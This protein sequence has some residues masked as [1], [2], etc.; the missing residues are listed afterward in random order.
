MLSRIIKFQEKSD[1]ELVFEIG[2]NSDLVLEN[3][4]TNNLIWTIEEFSKTKKGFLT[5]PTKFHMIDDILDLKGKEKIIIRMS[6]NPDIIINNVEIGTSKLDDRIRGVIKRKEAGYRV[7]I[8]I[9]PIILLEDYKEIYEQ[10]FIKIKEE[11]P[12]KYL[13][14]IFFELIFMTYSFVH[15]AINEE[16]FPNHIKIYEKEKFT[17]RGKGKYTY[18]KEIREEGTIFFKEMMNKYFPKSK[19]FYIS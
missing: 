7:G 10:L 12:E 15:N 19:L 14:E 11:I 6:L 17:S 9:A 2:S 3:T 13:D 8:L 16:A 5:F 18:K 4:I 1:D